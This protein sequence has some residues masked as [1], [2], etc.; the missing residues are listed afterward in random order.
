MFTT[1]IKASAHVRVAVFISIIVFVSVF[2]LATGR[3]DLRNESFEMDLAELPLIFQK[4]PKNFN[5]YHISQMCFGS[6]KS[7]TFNCSIRDCHMT[8]RDGIPLLEVGYCATYN[9]ETRR[10]SIAT[11]SDYQL[12]SYN[13]TSSGKYIQLP[14]DLSQLNEYMCGPLNK[15]V[16]CVEIAVMDLVPRSLHLVTGV[17]TALMLGTVCLS[18][19]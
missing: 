16:S 9:N 14:S 11:C 6:S 8:C 19:S 5:S 15:K 2:Q 10:I 17:S 12:G 7:G 1:M 4:G 18:F 13:V 3:A